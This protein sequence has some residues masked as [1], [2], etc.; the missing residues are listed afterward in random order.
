MGLRDRLVVMF[1][2]VAASIA[3]LQIL[4]LGE[5][6]LPMGVSISRYEGFERLMFIYPTLIAI[7]FFAVLKYDNKK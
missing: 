3:A 6:G 5:V 1:F 7:F 2:A 4:F